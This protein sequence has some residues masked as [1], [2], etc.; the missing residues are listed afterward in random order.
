MK[1]RRDRAD[2]DREDMRRGDWLT[3]AER[4][5]LLVLLIVFAVFVLLRVR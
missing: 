5:G 3:A 4:L 1:P 2:D